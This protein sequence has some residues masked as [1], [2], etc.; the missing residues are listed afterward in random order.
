MKLPLRLC[1]ESGLLVGSWTPSAPALSSRVVTH[2][3]LFS[4]IFLPLLWNEDEA[5][6]R[7]KHLFIN[8][9]ES[10][11]FDDGCSCK[12]SCKERYRW[13]IRSELAFGKSCEKI[14]IFHLNETFWRKSPQVD[15]FTQWC[16]HFH[17]QKA[18]S[19]WELCMHGFIMSRNAWRVSFVMMRNRLEEEQSSL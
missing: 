12:K 15:V 7:L 18:R 17:R 9:R 3:N 2:F 6:I 13:W 11:Y 10:G 16:T 8:N 14:I 19:W 5:D 1:L 4:F